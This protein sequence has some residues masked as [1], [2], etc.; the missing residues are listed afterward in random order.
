[1]RREDTFLLAMKGNYIPCA[2]A[3]STMAGRGRLAWPLIHGLLF[4]HGK[5]ILSMASNELR[6]SQVPEAG[7]HNGGYGLDIFQ[8]AKHSEDI[9]IAV[10]IMRC[11]ETWT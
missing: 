3:C 8:E 10:R 2:H 7:D 9:C 1:M 6:S 5:D 11:W 4:S